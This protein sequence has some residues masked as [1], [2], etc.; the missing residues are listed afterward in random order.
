M[1]SF[2]L[3]SQQLFNHILGYNQSVD[4]FGTKVMTEE[5]SSNVLLSQIPC[6][7]ERR[8]LSILHSWF[9]PLPSLLWKSEW[10]PLLS[11][12]WENELASSHPWRVL[13]LF[14]R[15]QNWDL[16]RIRW[17]LRFIPVRREV[18]R[19]GSAPPDFMALTTVFL[20]WNA[21]INDGQFFIC[22]AVW[23]SSTA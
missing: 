23:P 21:S 3:F 17:L 2:S 18:G 11:Q 15:W 4:D 6:T 8:F 9:H 10:K 22:S 14:L 19:L 20:R 5:W 1:N 16:E 7:E 13:F 12:G